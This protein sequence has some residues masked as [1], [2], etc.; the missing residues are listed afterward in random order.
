MSEQ[1]L[2]KR[3]R[4]RFVWTKEAFKGL[5]VIEPPPE[6]KASEGVEDK[7]TVREVERD[8]AGRIVRIV[9]RRVPAEKAEDGGSS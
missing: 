9:E 7:V 4:D 2:D 3:R 8:E 6:G 5:I 1:K